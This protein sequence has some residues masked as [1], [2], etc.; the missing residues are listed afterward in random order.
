MGRAMPTELVEAR[1]PG[2]MDQEVRQDGA[3]VL[4]PGVA[5]QAR[6]VDRMEARVPGVDGKSRSYG[7]LSNGM[8][9]EETA[10]RSVSS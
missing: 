4:H 9:K 2:A 5:V 6:G 1:P 7:L 8:A 3:E 10:C